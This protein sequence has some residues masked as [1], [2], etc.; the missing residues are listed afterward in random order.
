ME[1]NS[2]QKISIKMITDTANVN[3]GTF[4]LHFKDKNDLRDQCIEMHL[5]TILTMCTGNHSGAFTSKSAMT[6]TFEYLE[7]H[8]A[9]YQVMLT[10]VDNAYFRK[11]MEE[12]L[13]IGLSEY[14]EN[15]KFK[16]NLD[17]KIATQFIVCAGA[18]LIEW[19]LTN[20][21]DYNVDYLV[22][23]FWEIINSFR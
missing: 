5:N 3:R 13:H 1:K 4:Y 17:K 20:K 10:G 21:N 8:Y 23:Q 7:K 6:L 22:D 15:K 2:F 9:F 11:K 12:I 19:W 16:D 18:G 14:F